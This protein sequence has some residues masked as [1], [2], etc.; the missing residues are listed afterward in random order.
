MS[1]KHKKQITGEAKKPDVSGLLRTV[2]PYALAA[3]V[4]PFAL[5]GCASNDASKKDVVQTPSGY[6][7]LWGGPAANYVVLT[8]NKDGEVNFMR[9][10]VGVTRVIE[11]NDGPEIILYQGNGE[12]T[13]IRDF[14][15]VDKLYPYTDPNWNPRWGRPDQYLPFSDKMKAFWRLLDKSAPSSDKTKD[16]MKV[17]KKAQ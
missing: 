11:K 14:T 8:T 12:A 1:E 9:K 7:Q 5:A 6:T 10:F 13:L 4:L 16:D 17:S 2:R 15:E 3:A